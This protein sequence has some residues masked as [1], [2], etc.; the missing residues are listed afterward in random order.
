M[1]KI[2]FFLI[3]G[4]HFCIS[5]SQNIIIEGSP[6][7]VLFSAPFRMRSLTYERGKP[8]DYDFSKKDTMV[9]K[10]L[11]SY[12]K[13]HSSGIVGVSGYE[14]EEA[15]VFKFLNKKELIDIM[16]SGIKLLDMPPLKKGQSYE[17]RIERS[18]GYSL[19][20]RREGS[21][22]NFKIGGA[23]VNRYLASRI[24]NSL[25]NFNP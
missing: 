25:N 12:R 23:S 15:V 6:K 22:G 24:I 2:L 9:Y 10:L 19:T 5:S 4:F 14:T 20:I 11:L 1:K 7:K 8:N 13:Y 16:N 17:M 21:S 18:N 3:L